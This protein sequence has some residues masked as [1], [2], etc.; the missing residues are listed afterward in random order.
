MRVFPV[1][2]VEEM[3]CDGQGKFV[4]GEDYPSTFFGREC[5]SL[6]KL[7]EVGDPVFKLPFPIVPEFGS[8]I[9]PETWGEGKEP[10]IGGFG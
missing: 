4:S 5:D 3:R 2:K 9:G 1:D 10:L 7:L 8:D 6:F